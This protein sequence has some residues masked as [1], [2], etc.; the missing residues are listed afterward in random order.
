MNS[1]SLQDSRS[2]MISGTDSISKSTFF[3]SV[4]LGRSSTISDDMN[5]SQLMAEADDTTVES[6]TLLSNVQEVE[7]EK[8]EPMNNMTFD[9]RFRLA[10]MQI[11]SHTTHNFPTLSNHVSVPE[12][13]EDSYSVT[14]QR[15]G[16]ETFRA[17]GFIRNDRENVN[18]IITVGQVVQVVSNPE[19]LRYWSSSLTAFF[20]TKESTSRADN[21]RQY[22]AEWIEGIGSMKHPGQ[23]FYGTY[24]YIRSF[25]CFAISGSVKMF[26][27]RS[28]G[29]V[30][31][32]MGPVGGCEVTHTFTFKQTP[33]GVHVTNMVRVDR[34]NVNCLFMTQKV[35]EFILPSIASH[36]EQAKNSLNDLIQLVQSGPEAFIE[37]KYVS[38]TTNFDNDDGNAPLLNQVP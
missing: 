21:M 20:V 10:Q 16:E 12:M 31:I 19:L 17:Q 9:E 29:Q 32:T 27:E 33:S 30:A 6:S 36:M 18:D 2:S 8:E 1:Q 28:R 34:T 7:E 14:V 15:L 13:V 25:L 4:D 38:A 22:D 3:R 26:I 35:K 24:A 23:G 37:S 11:P 5:F